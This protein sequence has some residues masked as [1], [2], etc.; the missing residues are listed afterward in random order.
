MILSKM[1]TSFMNSRYGRK[2]KLLLHTDF[3]KTRFVKAKSCALQSK[4]NCV[5]HQRG[6]S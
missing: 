3:E 2:E 4:L 6:A 1:T 5:S